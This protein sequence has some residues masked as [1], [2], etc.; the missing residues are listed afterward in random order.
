MKLGRAVL[1][2]LSACGAYAAPSGPSPQRIACFQGC[3][4]GKDACLVEAT[5]SGAI[6]QC[7][8]RSEACGAGCPQ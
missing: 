2:L 6:Q 7:D 1:L 5:S 3:A 4:R 8:L